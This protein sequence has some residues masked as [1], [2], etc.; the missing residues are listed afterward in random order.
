MAIPGV[1]G[2]GKGQSGGEPCVRIF[3]ARE[4]TE[5]PKTIPAVRE[6]HSV[7]FEESGEFPDRNSPGRK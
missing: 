1:V 7:V 5:T 2:V 4:D 6:G 3:V